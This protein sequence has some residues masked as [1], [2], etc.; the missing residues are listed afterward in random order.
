MTWFFLAGFAVLLII[1]LIF[2][3]E[4]LRKQAQTLKLRLSSTENSNKNLAS[5][6]LL[7]AEELQYSHAVQLDSAERSGLIAGNEAKYYKALINC[8]NGVVEGSARQMTVQQSLTQ[9]L[10]AQDVTLDEVKTMIVDQDSQVRMAWS[11]NNL[12]GYLRLCR[13]IVARAQKKNVAG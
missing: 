4:N 7:V 8:I 12:S 2:R 9:C 3:G 1:F 6:L 10:P 11:K 5:E 13:E